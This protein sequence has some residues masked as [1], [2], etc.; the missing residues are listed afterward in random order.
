MATIAEIKSFIRRVRM[1]HDSRIAATYGPVATKVAGIAEGAQVNVLEGITVDGTTQTITNK[2][3]ALDL[4]AY[5]K[6]TDVTSSVRVKGSV[7]NFAALPANAEVG[8]MYHITAAGGT[9]ENGVAIKAGDN[10]VK[11]ATGWDNF[12]GTV[13]L[14][15]YVTSASIAD[16]R[17]KLAGIESGAQVNVIET[18][19]VDGV[20]LTPTSKAVDID[21]SG[22]VDKVNGKQLS[23]E[24]YTTAEK[25][26]LSGVAEGAQVNVLESV[27]VD[28]T[29]LTATNKGVNI[30]LSGKVDK[31]NGKGLSTNDFTDAYKTTVDNLNT[32]VNATFSD[33]DLTYIFA[34]SV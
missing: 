21:L 1:E 9:D 34:D 28:G 32:A 31:V 29:A 30:D 24:D 20:A 14:S 18:V 17:T 23:T 19:K 16:E 15:A 7:A 11:T 6:K 13:D 4:S 27:S 25:T 26:K 3:A 22:K 5:A 10:V 8:D 33:D 2:I 12:G